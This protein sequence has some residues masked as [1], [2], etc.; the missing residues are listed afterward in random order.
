M[1]LAGLPRR[2]RPLTPFGLGLAGLPW[3]GL[4]L[5]MEPLSAAQ[6]PAGSLLPLEAEAFR[7]RYGQE[8]LFRLR[9]GVDAAPSPSTDSPGVVAGDQPAPAGPCPPSGWAASAERRQFDQAV[10]QSRF[11][12]AGQVLGLWQRRHAA[13]P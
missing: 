2:L 3:A 10:E 7:A 5:A 8:A 1:R 4:L 6:L 13:C 12:A 9:L 11:Y